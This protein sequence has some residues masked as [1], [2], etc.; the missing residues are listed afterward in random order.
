MSE[1]FVVAGKVCKSYGNGDLVVPVLRDVSFTVARG[2]F[3]SVMGQSG[4]GKSTLLYLLGGL[5]APDQGEISIGGEGLARLT[6]EQ[7]SSFRR[8]RMGFVFQFFNLVP[9][10]TVEE[11]ILLPM[12][13]DGKK[14]RSLKPMLDSILETVELTDRRRHRPSELSG[15]QQQRVAIARAL[16]GEPDLILADEPTGNLDSETTAEVMELIARIN[17]EHGKTVIMVTHSPEC[18]AYGSRT[19]IVQD[20]SI[21]ES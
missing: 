13:L 1:P 9:N 17:T 21:V 2:E 14:R 8:N 16:I 19:V 15:G 6:D 12:L 4:S 10:L 7:M 18:A 3:V 5:D 11:N 20:G